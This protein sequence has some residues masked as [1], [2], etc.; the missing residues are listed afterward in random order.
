MDL[1]EINRAIDQWLQK[2]LQINSGAKDWFGVGGPLVK[3]IEGEEL[4]RPVTE[5]LTALDAT[6]AS[7]TRG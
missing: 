2:T 6:D 3:T 1:E 4:E 5:I 7:L